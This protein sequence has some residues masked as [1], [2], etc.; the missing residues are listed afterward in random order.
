MKYHLLI[1]PDKDILIRTTSD[2]ILNKLI[3]KNCLHVDTIKGF[4]ITFDNL[5]NSITGKE[6]L[7]EVD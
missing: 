2:N 7:E 1:A 3:D 6:Y 4:T 5:D